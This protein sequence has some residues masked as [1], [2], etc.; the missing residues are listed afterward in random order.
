[1]HYAP[2]TPEALALTG[3]A[4]MIGGATQSLVLTVLVVIAGTTLAAVSRL[5]G[6]IALEP[7]RNAAGEHRVGFTY[8][9]HPVRLRG[10]GTR[11][12]RRDQH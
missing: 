12:G 2:S 11:G 9:G 3:S 10:R 5:K 4:G 7:V 6:R 1:M 8:N